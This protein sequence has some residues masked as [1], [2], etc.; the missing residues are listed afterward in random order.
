VHATS[1]EGNVDIGFAAAPQ[2]ADVS[3]S[4]GNATVRVPLT[5]HRY[6]IVV[7][8]NAGTARSAVPDDRQ[9]HS[10]VHVSSVNGDATVRPLS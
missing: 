4:A 3:S 2:R 7:T 5:G 9:S 8:S 6:H 1:D 10:I